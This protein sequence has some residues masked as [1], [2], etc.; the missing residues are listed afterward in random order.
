MLKHAD[1]FVRKSG[2]EVL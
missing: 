1:Y 2:I